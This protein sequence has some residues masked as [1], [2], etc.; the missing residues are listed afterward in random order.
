MSKQLEPRLSKLIMAE[1]N[2]PVPDFGLEHT[3]STLSL[4]NA[5]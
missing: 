4:F 2:P 5:I 1:Q 3:Y